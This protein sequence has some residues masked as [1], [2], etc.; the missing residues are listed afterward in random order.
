M[1]EPKYCV[2][3]AVNRALGEAVV[4][5]SAALDAAEIAAQHQRTPPAWMRHWK[6][7]QAS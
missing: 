3:E 4:G 1:A 6:L 7:E 5:V 2:Y